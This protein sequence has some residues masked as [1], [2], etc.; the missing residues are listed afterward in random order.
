MRR[1]PSQPPV[2]LLRVKGEEGPVN[3]G[4]QKMVAPEPEQTG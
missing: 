3:P 2:Q 1:L 4:A